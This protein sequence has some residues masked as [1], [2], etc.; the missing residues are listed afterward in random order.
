MA[1]GTMGRRKS[2]TRGLVQGFF[3]LIVVITVY[4]KIE[5]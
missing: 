3:L 5:M 1:K 2:W 4:G